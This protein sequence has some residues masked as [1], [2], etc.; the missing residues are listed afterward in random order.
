MRR[1]QTGSIAI[2]GL[3]AGI[4]W[5]APGL[6]ASDTPDSA[7]VSRLLLDAK[8]ESYAIS[9]DASILESYTRQPRLNWETHASE[10]DRI[11]D[12]INAAARTVGKLSDARDGA[13]DWQ[14]VAINRIIPCMKEIADTTTSVIE[15]LNKNHTN[16]PASSEYK[17]YVEANSDTTREVAGM[18][19]DFVDYGNSKSRYDKLRKVLELPAR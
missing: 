3:L 13:S 16:L 2:A 19:A 8:T 14:V 12:D 1:L 6:K 15:Y 4:A 18:I 17:D 5:L 11:K 10:I 7:P 9:V